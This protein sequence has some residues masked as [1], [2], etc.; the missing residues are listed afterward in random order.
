M[1]IF[2]CAIAYLALGLFISIILQSI[3]LPLI[4]ILPFGLREEPFKTF[5]LDQIIQSIS[6]VI[7]SLA[8]Y[9]V[10]DTKISFIEPIPKNIRYIVFVIV[11]VS[12]IILSPRYTFL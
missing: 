5:T 3:I 4:L 1:K 2:L 10:M 6:I 8:N 7:I 12:L 11:L 9:F